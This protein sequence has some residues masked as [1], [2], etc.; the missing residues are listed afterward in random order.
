M[1]HAEKPTVEGRRRGKSTHKKITEEDKDL[2]IDGEE[3]EKKKDKGV[4]GDGSEEKKF[5][6]SSGGVQVYASGAVEKAVDLVEDKATIDPSRRQ[7]KSHKKVDT[8]PSPTTTTT[9]E[10]NAAGGST[11]NASI[12]AQLE[13]DSSSGVVSSNAAQI[14]SSGAIESTQVDLDDKATISASR[15]HKSRKPRAVGGSEGE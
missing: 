3:Y 1:E 11:F 2:D 4:G 8:L 13:H 5:E 12:K 14:Y 10:T 6:S 9:N 15:R 7:K